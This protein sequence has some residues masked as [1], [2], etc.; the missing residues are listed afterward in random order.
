MA[1][2]TVSITV[3]PRK[4][5]FRYPWMYIFC[6][7]VPQVGSRVAARI[8]GSC[9]AASSWSLRYRAVAAGITRSFRIAQA[10]LAP[11]PSR[12]AGAAQVERR[13]PLHWAAWIS[14][15]AE[16]RL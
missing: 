2:F 9:R 12:K 8:S 10:R 5:P 7:S 11:A 6:V 4:A 1:E 3:R 13:T 16:S 15:S 14:W